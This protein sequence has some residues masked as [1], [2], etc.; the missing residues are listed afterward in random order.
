MESQNT[1]YYIDK[2]KDSRFKR[3]PLNMTVHFYDISFKYW[4]LHWCLGI[5]SDQNVQEILMKYP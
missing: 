4:L 5:Y 2:N 1:P 3:K